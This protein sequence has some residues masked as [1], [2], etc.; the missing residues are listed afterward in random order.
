ME[1]MRLQSLLATTSWLG[2]TLAAT[3][4]PS[5][6]FQER[7][8][9]D[10]GRAVSAHRAI[11]D[12]GGWVVVPDAPNLR[13]G[14]AGQ[15]VAGLRQRLAASGDLTSAGAGG[16][17]VFDQ[18]LEAG[19]KRFQRRH[20]LAASGVLDGETAAA[21]NVP[22]SRRL[23]QIKE[24]LARVRALSQDQAK[25]F[26]LVNIA[27]QRLSLFENG[28]SVV[29]MKVIIGRP[30]NPTPTLDS[31]IER[32]VINPVW[33]LPAGPAVEQ[34]L[35]AIRADPGYLD[36][37]NIQVLNSADGETNPRLIDW[38]TVSTE[39][40]RYRLRQQ[41]GPAN[42]LGRIEFVFANKHGVHLHD[43]PNKTLF[44]DRDRRKSLGCVRLERATDLA[45]VLLRAH[46]KWPRSRMA[47][48]ITA[49]ATRTIWL[50]EPVDIHIV[51][52]PAWSDSEGR[53]QIRDDPY[54]LISPPLL[55]NHAE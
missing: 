22:A 50:D 23:R 40:L 54:P 16:E 37:A 8:L 39:T 45:G 18:A 44:D 14:N 43:T 17:A 21:I 15:A 55:P 30:A 5:T 1:V 3:G 10:L 42:P 33:N 46:S 48:A 36:S 13:L 26:I 24:S 51:D 38:P 2:L 25:S 11:N 29:R 9:R 28:R 53:L 19:L 7:Q 52:W 20:G 31:K 34:V 35:A 6:S 49:G 41:S 27:D 4:Q 12:R 32:I 47:E